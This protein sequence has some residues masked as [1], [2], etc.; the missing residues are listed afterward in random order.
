[1]KH[2]APA[3]NVKT[4]IRIPQPLHIAARKRALDEGLD[5]QELVA[6]ALEQYLKLRGTR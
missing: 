1:M 5:F 6:R 2:K 3:E 4:T